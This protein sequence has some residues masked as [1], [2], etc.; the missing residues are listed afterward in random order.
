MVGGQ[1]VPDL[2]RDRRRQR[3]R[4]DEHHVRAEPV[5]ELVEVHGDD[6]AGHQIELVRGDLARGPVP[7][8]PRRH[9]APVHGGHQHD[10]H[11]AAG[12]QHETVVPGGL[13][14]Q[15][16]EQR[17]QRVELQQ[18]QQVVELVVA[19]AEEV[20]QVDACPPSACRARWAGRPG[21]R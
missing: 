17:E 13:A 18:D 20:E 5:V 14:K 10:L 2:G 19:G 7:L 11:Q 6:H 1:V 3:A 9:Q 21:S 16:Q 4:H 12:Q 15:D 8:H